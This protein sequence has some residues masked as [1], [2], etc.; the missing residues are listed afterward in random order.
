MSESFISRKE[1]V[2]PAEQIAFE[3]AFEGVLTKHFDDPS[4]SRQFTTLS[5]FGKLLSNPELLA[6]FINVVE[7]VGSVLVRAED[8]EVGDVVLHHV[9]Q[10]HSQRPG[11]LEFD[12]AGFIELGCVVA[13]VR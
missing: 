8:T 6:H 9:A 7:L 4:I 3:H 1:T 10:K 5:V 11:I 13:K 2:S 12:F